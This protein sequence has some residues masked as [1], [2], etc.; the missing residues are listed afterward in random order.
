MSIGHNLKLTP[1]SELARIMND[2]HYAATVGIPAYAAMA[3]LSE[4]TAMQKAMQNQAQPTAPAPSV[5]QQVLA[6][7][8]VAAL[9]VNDQMFNAPS[10]GI[11]YAGEQPQQAPTQHMAQGGVIAFNGEDEST[12][13]YNRALNN[14][15]LSDDN[16]KSAFQN[17]PHAANLAL[18]GG[19]YLVDKVTG[20]R[21]IRNPYTGELQRASDVVESPNAGKLAD[22]GPMS[23]AQST[24]PSGLGSIPIPFSSL[25]NS[26]QAQGIKQNLASTGTAPVA[27]SAISKDKSSMVEAGPARAG[28]PSFGFDKV[29]ASQVGDHAQE[30]KDLLRPEASAQAEMDRYKG[31]IGIDP[32]RERIDAKMKAM[33]AKTAKEEEAIPAN[34]LSQFGF[35]LMGAKKG[36]VG[37]RASEAALTATKGTVDAKTRIEA[38]REKQFEAQSRQ[39]QADRAEQV[40]AAKFGIESEEHIKARNDATKAAAIT[41]KATA[42][43]TNATNSLKAAETNAKNKLAAQ[44]LGVTAQHYNDW[45]NISLDKAKKDLQGIEKA[46]IAE[47]S[48]AFTTMLTQAQ[49]DLS[50]TRSKL[51]TKEEIAAAQARVNAIMAY[52]ADV[53]DMDLPT[54]PNPAA[55]A[56]QKTKTG[57]KF[58]Y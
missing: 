56:L 32:N 10:T 43:A 3:Q 36:Q 30:F 21:W 5:K 29:T 7:A 37:S 28:I 52:G 20:L 38:A 35:G 47:K 57:Y 40:T 41:A 53:L 12:V 1:S 55:G 2:P 4:R 9:P 13:S 8:G 44:E 39:A 48:R 34:W 17:A 46:T 18:K 45:Y 54:A 42:E 19:K 14:S 11:A 49:K 15:F 50:D 33:E 51:G 22:M 6:N 58:G 16:I 23:G 27:E 24:F 31:L 26:E 25:P